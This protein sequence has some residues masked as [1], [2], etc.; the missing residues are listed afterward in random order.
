MYADTFLK[1]TSFMMACMLA[2]SGGAFIAV[3]A[4]TSCAARFLRIAVS[5]TASPVNGVPLVIK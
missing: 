2:S 4:A 5:A 1:M 3:F